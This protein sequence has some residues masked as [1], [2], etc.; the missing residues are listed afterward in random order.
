MVYKI[1]FLFTKVYT[2]WATN[3]AFSKCRRTKKARICEKGILII[4]DIQDF[5]SQ[6]DI[7]E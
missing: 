5:L 2:L 7:E 1:I 4:K 6:K 3:K